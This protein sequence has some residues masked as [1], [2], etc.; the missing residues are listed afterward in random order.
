MASLRHVQTQGSIILS[1]EM[2]ERLYLSPP[3]RAKGELRQMIGNP[4]PFA[5]AGFIIAFSPLIFSFLGWRHFKGGASATVGAFYFSGG[6]LPILGAVFELILGNTFSACYF[7]VYGAW[8][9]GFGANFSP[10][11]GAYLAYS[12]DPNNPRLGA[13]QPGYLSGQA[14][15][16]LLMAIFSFYIT[17]CCFR[18]NI[19]LVVN[20]FCLFLIF[21]FAAASFWLS[22]DGKTATTHRMQLAAGYIGFVA[23]I[24]DLYALLSLLFLTVDFP[25]QLP[26]GDLSNVFPTCGS[27]AARRA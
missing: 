19:C 21:T 23:L 25:V 10:D 1:P 5:L 3:T 9:L 13:L 18:T 26:V 16:A 20:F 11:F 12:P 24:V 7:A 4:T 15:W 17:I 22:I 2:F 8:F 27:P 14:Y 6:L